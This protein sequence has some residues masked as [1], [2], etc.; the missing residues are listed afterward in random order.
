MRIGY[1]YDMQAYPPRGGNHVHAGELVQGFLANGHDVFVVNDPTMPGVQNFSDSEDDLTR[2]L[3]NIDILYIRIDARFIAE[4]R[5]VNFC[6]AHAERRPVVWEINS[7]ADESLAF[8]WLSGRN[9]S[10]EAESA[11]RK[12]RRW[13]HAFRKRPGI[14]FEERARRELAKRVDVAICVSSALADYARDDLGIAEAVVMPNGGP[15]VDLAEIESRRAKS[16]SGSDEFRVLYSGSAIYPWQGLD[17]LAAVIRLAQ[18]EAPDISFVLAVNQK[19]HNLPDS[20]RIVILEKLD[21]EKILDA[22]CGA[23]VCVSIHPQYPW[24]KHGFHNSPMKLFEYMA[25]ARASVTSDHGQ[26]AELIRDGQD[27]LLCQNDPVE[28]LAKLKSLRDDPELTQQLGMNAW[29]RIQQEFSWRNHV[30]PK[31]LAVFES[32]LAS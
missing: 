18:T 23:D 11:F 25:C 14:Y 22:I 15:L 17:Y 19:H 32:K 24:A 30:V 1:L 7:P 27:G 16:R 4:W 31:T 10:G 12:F 5:A 28:I 26:M 21:R 29:Q 8:S 20:D 6:M 13:Q 2:F 9:L 3:S